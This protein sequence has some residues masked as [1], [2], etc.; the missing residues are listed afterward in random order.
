MTDNQKN[1]IN[2]VG[3]I[4]QEQYRTRDKWV[5]P[6]VCIAQAILESGWNLESKTL[7]GIKGSGVVCDT[8][9]YING[10]WISTK[11]EFVNY[12]SIADS[13]IGYYD[14]ITTTPRYQYVVNNS[15]YE[16]AVWCLIHTTDGCPYATA[17]NYIEVILSLINDYEL[18]KWD[19]RPTNSI[20]PLEEFLQSMYNIKNNVDC[21]I[22]KVEKELNK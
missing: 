15:D 20:N 19:S 6:S 5:L 4:A 21:L 13:I 9:E 12:P 11:A 8:T 7:F 22:S 3:T 17:P 16:N 10:E 2:V 1:F 14:F 18:Y